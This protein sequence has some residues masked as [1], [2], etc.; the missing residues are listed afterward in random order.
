MSVSE[1]EQAQPV[2]GERRMAIMSFAHDYITAEWRMSVTS[3]RGN[4][5]GKFLIVS[6]EE[7]LQQYSEIAKRYGAGFEYNDF[8][9]PD[10]LDSEARQQRILRHYSEISLPDYCTMHG[11]FLDVTV[12]SRD[13]KIRQISMLRMEQSMELAKK[14]GA[15]GVVFHTNIN[16][17]LLSEEYKEYAVDMTAQSVERLLMRYPDIQIYME[18]MFDQTP[19]VLLQ[20]S[21][22]LSAYQNYGVCLDY[23]HAGISAQPVS[24][25]VL[26]LHPYIKHLHISDHDGRQDLHLA[27]G[28]GI[29]DWQQFRSHYKKYF[30]DCSVLIETARPDWQLKSIA[31]LRQLGVM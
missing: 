18:N 19:E 26:V 16:P 10:V 9:R 29:T 27:V 14:A 25:W 15:K 2:H 28:D 4:L 1:P 12:F 7:S 8:Y 20:I 23:A 21:K 30:E 31:Y 11:A 24:E 13:E 22:K 3:L 17:F 6:V 5:M